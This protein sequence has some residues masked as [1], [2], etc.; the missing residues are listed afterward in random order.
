MYLSTKED[1]IASLKKR[2]KN[3][4]KKL[5]YFLEKNKINNEKE[6]YTIILR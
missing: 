3:S 1:I 4:L 6:N 2:H 5:S